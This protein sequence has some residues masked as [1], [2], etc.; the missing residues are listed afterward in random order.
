MSSTPAPGLHTSESPL[1]LAGP[2]ECYELLKPLAQAHD[3]AVH[4]SLCSVC[5]CGKS[6]E[7]WD[8]MSWHTFMYIIHVCT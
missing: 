7:A 8:T 3:V 1:L 5:A 2:A 4:D 6:V